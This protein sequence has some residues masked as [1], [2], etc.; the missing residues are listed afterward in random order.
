MSMYATI[1]SK[2]LML[3]DAD[4]DDEA[5]AEHVCL[6]RANLPARDLGA[7]TWSREAFV[8]EV[9]YDRALVRLADRFD[10]DVARR[11]FAHPGIERERLESELVRRG[12]IREFRERPTVDGHVRW[13]GPPR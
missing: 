2:A 3:W 8:A 5:L 1:L 10:I 11:N 12:V 6:C 7:G 13:G 9:L 4:L